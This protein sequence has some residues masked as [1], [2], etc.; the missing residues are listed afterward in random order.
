MSD[1]Q[2][3]IAPASID[4][5]PSQQLN[6]EEAQAAEDLDQDDEFYEHILGI[7]KSKEL[8]ELDTADFK[9][10]VDFGILSITFTVYRELQTD[11][12]FKLKDPKDLEAL[13][14]MDPEYART[15]KELADYPTSGKI[16]LCQLYPVILRA[17]LGYYSTI[18][19]SYYEDTLATRRTN[20]VPIGLNDKAFGVVC[21]AVTKL[22]KMAKDK[23]EASI[24]EGDKWQEKAFENKEQASN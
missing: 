21:A 19:H 22:V 8:K 5:P 10:L 16:R 13:Q 23:E 24:E 4:R 17:T 7:H 1:A 14:D 9:F 15:Q 12:F 6:A 3:N 2:E 20:Q 11:A 18:A